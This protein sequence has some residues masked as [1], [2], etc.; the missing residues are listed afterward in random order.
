MNL[1]IPFLLICFGQAHSFQLLLGM[2]GSQA[3]HQEAVEHPTKQNKRVGVGL[4][5]RTSRNHLMVC[6]TFSHV[7]AC[8]AALI[9]EQLQE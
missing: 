4:E 8:T 6:V 5:F 7:A 2:V 1:L 3:H 9:L